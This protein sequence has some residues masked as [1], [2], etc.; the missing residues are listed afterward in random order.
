MGGSDDNEPTPLLSVVE[1]LR[2][3]RLQEH[4]ASVLG[5][6][7]RTVNPSHQ[8]LVNPS[9]PIGMDA[10][11]L[12]QSLRIGEE[13]E[14]LTPQANPPQEL[15]SLMTNL[16]VTYAAVPI[17]VTPQQ[18]IAYFVLGPMMVGPREDEQQFHKRVQVMGIDPK[19]FWPILLSLKLYS[20]VSIRSALN[21]MEEVGN[22][23]VQLAYQ[24]IRLAAI[25][26]ATPKVD[27]AVMSYYIDQVLNSLLE[28]ATL[29]TR[30]DGGSVMIYEGQDEVL[31]IKAAQGLSESVVADTR[32]KRGEG[33]A[34]LAAVR[35]SVLLVD[36]QTGDA[37]LKPLMRRTELVSSLIAPLILEP[38]Q[39][40]VGVLS[41]R[42][43][44]RNGRFTR[45]HVEIVRRLLDLTS[46]ALANVKLVFPKPHPA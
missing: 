9:W 6:P 28:V 36:D 18:V 25:L 3:Q 20:F 15:S 7:I 42:T 40:P 35:R 29:A 22:S 33:L 16:G 44:N 34:G 2:W 13:L 5:L 32:Q 31:T 45:E 10:E 46:I 17:R 43:A 1:P 12:I 30:A 27:Q 21:L 37:S 24:A 39:E 4:F 26:P 11:R 23:L 19:A 38:E 14:Q 41:L 8:L